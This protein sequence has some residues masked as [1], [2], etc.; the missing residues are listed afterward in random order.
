MPT[1]LMFHKIIR[2]VLY[3]FFYRLYY[4]GTIF[5]FSFYDHGVDRYTLRSVTK[6][7]PFPSYMFPLGG[8]YETPNEKK[9]AKT[10]LFTWHTYPRCGPSSGIRERI[11]QE[12]T[13]KNLLICNKK[14]N[15][16]FTYTVFIRHHRP[17][18]CS[19]STVFT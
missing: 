19:Q 13:N 5:F 8:F 4:V 17:W 14:K 1:L 18:I 11:L 9:R 12:Q 15:R 3:F 2:L 10:W 7:V 6:H 16:T